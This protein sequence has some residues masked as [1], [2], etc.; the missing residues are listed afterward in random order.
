MAEVTTFRFRGC[1][2][3]SPTPAYPVNVTTLR[4]FSIGSRIIRLSTG[5]KLDIC[6]QIVGVYRNESNQRSNAIR[7]VIH[8][9]NAVPAKQRVRS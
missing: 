5:R 6:Y 9:R 2:P 1:E 3:D 7:I 4:L 8:I